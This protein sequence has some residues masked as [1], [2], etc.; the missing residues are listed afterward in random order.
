MVS[1]FEFMWWLIAANWLCQTCWPSMKVSILNVWWELYCNLHLPAD[2]NAT[3][4]P[5]AIQRKRESLS[6]KSPNR[7]QPIMLSQLLCP[8]QLPVLFSLRLLCGGPFTVRIQLRLTL[9]PSSQPCAHTNT[10]P[11]CSHGYGYS[12]GRRELS[13]VSVSE[14]LSCPHLNSHMADPTTVREGCIREL[15]YQEPSPPHL[16]ARS[17]CTHM[18]KALQGREK[19]AAFDF[20]FF[21]S[22]NTVSLERS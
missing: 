13:P 21:I 12:W 6:L 2:L 15:W 11:T 19:H 17:S 18:K 20:W 16:A 9:T 22:Q 8:M 10:H 7:C 5:L 3:E 4:P 14:A 1:K